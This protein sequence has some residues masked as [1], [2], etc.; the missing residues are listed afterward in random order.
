MI[1]EEL[2]KAF[3]CRARRVEAMLRTLAPHHEGPVHFGFV[4]YRNRFER[5]T[6]P[7][8]TVTRLDQKGRGSKMQHGM[9]SIQPMRSAGIDAPV[10]MPRLEPC[11]ST[12]SYTYNY[13]YTYAVRG[14]FTSLS[15]GDAMLA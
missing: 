3:P 12:S 13:S 11:A 14:R 15:F 10:A 5:Y 4:Y 1:L 6:L 9:V 8:A 7:N 2:R